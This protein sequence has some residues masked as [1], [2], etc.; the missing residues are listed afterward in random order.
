ML[1]CDSMSVR[2]HGIDV[3]VGGLPAAFEMSLPCPFS[4]L[5]ISCVPYKECSLIPLESVLGGGVIA[6]IG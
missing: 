5:I 1:I 3:S 2:F 4:V 6:S